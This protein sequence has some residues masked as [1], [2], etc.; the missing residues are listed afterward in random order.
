LQG[1]ENTSSTNIEVKFS[2]HGQ[3]GSEPNVFF[4]KL[5]Q[6]ES[7]SKRMMFLMVLHLCTFAYSEVRAGVRSEHNVMRDSQVNLH[8]NTLQD[9][10]ALAAAWDKGADWATEAEFGH[11]E[12]SKKHST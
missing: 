7:A 3:Y 2:R 8:C 4:A 9:F 6:A 10:T 5:L 1:A 11:K 12:A